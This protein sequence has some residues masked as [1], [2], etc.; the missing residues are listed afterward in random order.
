MSAIL[1]VWCFDYPNAVCVRWEPTAAAERLDDFQKQ[2]GKKKLM[3]VHAEPSGSGLAGGEMGRKDDNTTV[4]MGF[5]RLEAVVSVGN[6]HRM[7]WV[8]K[9]CRMSSQTTPEERC[10][11]IYVELSEVELVCSG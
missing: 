3:L 9:L 1:F 11:A 5:S 8:E 2:D 7:Q 4:E 6:Y 10:E